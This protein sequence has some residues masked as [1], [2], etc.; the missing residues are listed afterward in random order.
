MEDP[1]RK[2]YFCLVK[3]YHSPSLPKENQKQK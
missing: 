1:Q 3:Q 2:A